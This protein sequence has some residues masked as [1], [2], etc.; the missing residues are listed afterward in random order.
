MTE[1]PFSSVFAAADRGVPTVEA[2]IGRELADWTNSS[3]SQC[4]ETDACESR[5]WLDKR[6]RFPRVYRKSLAL[7]TKCHDEAERYLLDGTAPGPIIAS[8]LHRLP[9]P[10]LDPAFVELLF[11][12]V[13]PELPVPVVGKIDLLEPA[14]IGPRPDFASYHRIT[15]HKT[16]SSFRYM[17]APEQLAHDYQALIY[18]AAAAPA[19]YG[20]DTSLGDVYV[21][22]R[23][24]EDGSEVEERYPMF[25][26]DLSDEAL[27]D[28]LA[29]RH[30]YYRTAARLNPDSRESEVRLS[31]AQIRA[32][33]RDKVRPNVRRQAAIAE[34]SDVREVGFDLSHCSNY[35][36][37]QFKTLCAG[38]GRKTLGA[39]SFFFASTSPEGDP[40][41]SLLDNL[42][43]NAAAQSGAPA[44]TP[45]TSAN[46]LLAGL[47]KQKAAQSAPAPLEARSEASGD[48][49]T[50]LLEGAAKQA[51]LLEPRDPDAEPTVN[52]P[53]GVDADA[54]YVE[55]AA[56]PKKNDPVVPAD[57][58]LPEELHKYRGERLKALKKPQI[59]ELYPAVRGLVRDAGRLKIWSAKARLPKGAGDKLDKNTRVELRDDL[60]LLLEILRVPD[61]E[62]P[63]LSPQT[64]EEAPQSTPEAEEPTQT[65]EQPEEAAPEPEEQP[66]EAVEAPADDYFDP[67]LAAVALPF[68]RVLFVDCAPRRPASAVF[69]EELLRPLQLEAAK[70]L[71]VVSY[72]VPQYKRGEDNVVARLEQGIENGTIPLP[73]VLVASTS[74]PNTKI[75]L[76][77]LL[78]HY[79]LVVERLGW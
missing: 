13:D 29:F 4:K 37:C 23:T 79:D 17:L 18:L 16:T 49:P 24:L 66:E 19:F 5:Q 73:A 38:L 47:A 14:G 12:I 26:L 72:R 52:P 71:S 62:V 55:P 3:P 31:A 50:D 75:A 46:P 68:G 42:K 43:K 7:G 76:E 33:W 53:D 32:G 25:R 10:P 35:G 9:A 56:P 67:N 63:S 77:A 74:L 69:L 54:H 64:D 8:G 70:E 36:G 2:L 61:E 45:A 22:V 27:G 48:P 65:D 11:A 44:S 28:G 6:A 39:A 59:L 34:A 40:N 58:E 60:E 15:D 57:L 20:V 51:D 41:V 1:G 30:V 21:K 78:P